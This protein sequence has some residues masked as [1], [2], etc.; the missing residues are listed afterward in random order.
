MTIVHIKDFKYGQ[1]QRRARAVG[2]PGSLWTLRNAHISRGGDI[3]RMKKWAEY[4]VLPAGTFGLTNVFGQLVTFGSADLAASMPITVQYQRLTAP[5]G[6]SMVQLLD[7]QVF[8]DKIYTIARFTD[9]SIHHYYD[10]TLIADWDTLAAAAVSPKW[11]VYEL[12]VLASSEAATVTLS[13]GQMIR[14]TARVPGV[15][16]TYAATGAGATTTIRQANVV[17]VPEVDATAM[18][19]IVGGPAGAFTTSTQPAITSLLIEGHEMIHVP[20]EWDGSVNNMAIALVNA[21]NEYGGVVPCR[22]SAVANVVT[23]TAGDGKG[24]T[25]N[26]SVLTL[27]YDPSL[28]INKTNFAGGVTYVA[29]VAQIIDIDYP[30]A[31]TAA[32]LLTLTLNGTTYKMLGS[33]ASMGTK[34]MAYKQRMWA[35]AGTLVRYSKLNDPANWTDVTAGFIDMPS[36][37]EGSERLQ[38]LARYD[39]QVAIFGTSQIRLWQ[40]ETDPL[41]NTSTQTLNNTGTQSPIGIVQ[42]GDMDVFYL[43]SPGIR[44]LKARS[45]VTTAAVNDVGTMLDT[46]LQNLTKAMDRALIKQAVGVLDPVD[47][48]Y[49]LAIDDKMIVLSAFA[50][51]K[52]SAWSYYEPGFRCSWFARQRKG[53]FA[54]DATKIYLYGGVFGDEYPDED[55]TPVYVETP[56]ISAEE[57]GTFKT[58]TAFMAIC[59]NEWDVNILLDPNDEAQTVPVGIV[60]GCTFV[61]Q[62]T[63]VEGAAN[64]MALKMTCSRGGKATFSSFAVE[65]NK[66]K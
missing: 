59:E 61:E 39:Q 49:I 17:E 36:E 53:L 10:G 16:F 31:I 25:V 33:A 30:G 6:E 23:I 41:K 8:S 38:S 45:G 27:V 4:A 63:P 11:V 51:S 22:A 47:G 26:G 9:G 28:T 29:P 18:I 60:H 43:D 32:T 2:T 24:A 42:Y 62:Y 52:I 58:L 1:D 12:G 40:L 46:W 13:S 57:P 56:F 19:T 35:V 64:M 34:V 14:V 55:E 66:A 5:A 7:A 20:I 37:G 15:P 65:F 44:S 54:R 48:R 50:N 3:E 21:I